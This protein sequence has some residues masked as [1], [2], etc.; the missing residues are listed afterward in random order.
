MRAFSL[1]TAFRA[2]TNAG[3]TTLPSGDR[4]DASLITG[5]LLAC[6]HVGGWSGCALIRGGAFQGRALDVVV[7]VRKSA[8]FAAAG[9]RAGYEL[10]I[11]GSVAARA[12]IE[13]AFPLTRTEITINNHPVWTAPLVNGGL[14]LGVVV[15]F[16]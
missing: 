15:A 10:P 6:R 2:E 13:A 16:P 14:A 8:P 5:T 4:V 9:L 7:P 11:A 3:S 1:E 12:E